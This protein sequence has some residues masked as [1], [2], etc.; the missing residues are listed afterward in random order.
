MTRDVCARVEEF[1]RQHQY[2][3]TG[4]R[5]EIIR[6]LNASD[7][8]LSVQ[9]IHQQLNDTAA[10][11]ASVYRTINLLCEL[12]VLTKL[13][14]QEKLYRYELSDV[15]APHHHHL[16]C[17]Q[18]GSVANVFEHCLPDNVMEQIRTQEGFTVESHIL[19]FYGLCKV[20]T[21]AN[22]MMPD[23]PP[24]ILPR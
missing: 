19:E 15:F 21:P 16:I 8:P 9:E 14:F 10:D 20:C 1:L 2:K 13:D 3:L 23:T 7:R 6:I 17:K 4:A 24:E 22:P 5:K 12:G 11:L 18:C